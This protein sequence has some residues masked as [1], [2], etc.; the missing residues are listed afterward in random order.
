MGLETGS[1]I[2]D[3]NTANPPG[4]DPV[5]QGDDHLRLLKTVDKNTFAGFTG[6]V[7]CRGPESG[8]AA[9]HV[10]TPVVAAVS[11]TTGMLLSYTPTNIGVGGALTVNVSALGAKSIKTIQGDDPSAGDVSMKPLI[12]QYDG[13]NFVTVAGSVFLSKTGNQTITGN[14][15]HTGN[16]AVSGTLGVTG[17]TSLVD[18][19]ASGNATF[20]TQALGDTSTKAATTSFV[21]TAVNAAAFSTALPGQGGNS[22]KFVTTNGT[23]AS[24]SLVPLATG[25]SGNLP[26][27]NLN[28]GTSASA[29][30][31]WRGDGTW[32]V[33]NVQGGGSQVS[34]G[35]NITL[36]SASNRVES[37]T[38]TTTGLTVSLPDATT[39]TTGGPTFIL[40]GAAASNAGVFRDNAGN[41]LTSLVAGTGY[42][43]NLVDNSTAAGVWLV[44]TFSSITQLIAGTATVG[45]AVTTT[46]IKVTTLTSTTALCAF[47]YGGTGFINSCVI[48]VTNGVTSFG[49]I[50]ANSFAVDSAAY[51]GLATLSATQVIL[52]CRDGATTFLSAVCINISGGV[53]SYGTKLAVN[54]VASTY[55][56]VAALSATQ[57]VCTYEDGSFVPYA[58]VLSVSGSTITNGTPTS[59]A[60]VSAGYMGLTA[61]SATKLICSMA[62]GSTVRSRVIDVSG[63]VPTWGSLADVTIGSTPA[64]MSLATLTSTKAICAFQGASNFLYAVILDISG[65]TITPAT[66]VT[67]SGT[68]TVSYV[69]VAS[70]SATQAIV[71]YRDTTGGSITR[72]WTQL[73]TV[74]T[75]TITGSTALNI[76]TDNGS[77]YNAVCAL[78]ANKALF[79]QAGTSSF[80]NAQTLE[81]SVSV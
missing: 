75:S 34:S 35:T 57:A 63:T 39:L 19:A 59:V 22:G 51:I 72:Q 43:F 58:V 9:A 38:L 36:T 7:I 73:L 55:T 65:S 8:T 4:G 64:Y 17:A 18:L 24:W 1:F 74:A 28:S 62:T 10:V 2:N 26:V 45:N 32:G 21:Q 71:V 69:A 40:S 70:F 13:T 16:V 81:L 52:T 67:L 15:T 44:K 11:Y 80:L 46:Y 60:A 54:A 27:T 53:P 37:I 14:I 68:N 31:F 41:A 30:T 56:S 79:A 6:I 49:T 3:L 5:S 66:V 50:V 48:T 20:V 78:S 47:Y 23:V 76:G 77:P 42:I 61:L 12:L 25:V 33:I 29:T